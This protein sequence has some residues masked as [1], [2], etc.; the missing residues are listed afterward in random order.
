MDGG[1]RWVV[2]GR[3]GVVLPVGRGDSYVYSGSAYTM[4][5]EGHGEGK[6]SGGRSPPLAGGDEFNQPRL[7]RL[8]RGLHEPDCQHTSAG[9]PG[10]GFRTAPSE[11]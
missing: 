8:W 7:A 6:K 3:R 10:S 4:A 11:L 2:P 9:V 1:Q 5:T